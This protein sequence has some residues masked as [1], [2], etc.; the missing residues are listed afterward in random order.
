MHFD[1]PDLLLRTLTL[2]VGVSRSLCHVSSSQEEL[3][4]TV[5]LHNYFIYSVPLLWGEHAGKDDKEN[6]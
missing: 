3:E 6:F 1:T 5:Y 2:Y 4:N